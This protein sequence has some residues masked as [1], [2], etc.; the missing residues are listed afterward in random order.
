M[1][2]L[3][4]QRRKVFYV[5]LLKSLVDGEYYIG[6]TSDIEKR[7]VGHNNG[8]VRATRC[9]RPLRL[10]GKELLSSREKARF[11]EYELKN[12]AAKR[13]AFYKKFDKDKP[14]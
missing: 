14:S 8:F 11:R 10:L 3:P 1:P 12:S 13:A 5:Y 7:L 9:R 6:Q 2:T 4:S